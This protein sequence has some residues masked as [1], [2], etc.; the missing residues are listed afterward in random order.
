MN[1]F[2][3]TILAIGLLA[4]P[5]LLQARDITI[6][7]STDSAII[8]MGSQFNL[9]VQLTVPEAAAASVATVNAPAITNL[10]ENFGAFGPVYV[11][12]VQSDTTRAQDGDLNIVNIYT[13]QGFDPGLYTLPRVGLTTGGGDTLWSQLQ[14]L[15]VLPM[16]VDTVSM[17]ARPLAG[18]A[19]PNCRWYDYIPLW[20]FWALAGLA[21]AAAIVFAA[22]KFKRKKVMEA[23][24]A[25]TPVPPYELAV[26]RLERLRKSG[27]MAPGHEKGFYTELTDILRKYLE[28]R[29]G[30]NAM[31]M[32][33]SQIMRT[34]RANPATRIPSDRMDEV[35]RIADFVKFAK[36]RPLADDN[37]RALQRSMDFVEDTKPQPE[38]PAA[39]AAKTGAPAG[40]TN[41][42]NRQPQSRK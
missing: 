40:A 5:A 11:T 25:E 4:T 35:L 34:L 41:I 6:S 27:A 17:A 32:T 26:S 23:V 2:R 13:L 30:I 7:A 42:D 22:L 31:E 21:L 10:D 16:N 37:E 15:K 9:T 19:S 28:G 8:L 1:I 24:K 33:S 39:P 38:P 18:V 14:T 36:E 12:A 3:S 29:F 20:L